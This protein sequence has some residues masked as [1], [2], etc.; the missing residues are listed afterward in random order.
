MV[1][2]TASPVSWR[3]PKKGKKYFTVAEANRA[4][5]YVSRIVDEISEHYQ[6]VMALRKEIEQGRHN[7]TKS[8]GRSEYEL[9]MDRLN[10]LIDELHQ[11]GVELKDLELGLLDFP[12][13]H[14]GREIY[15]CW[16]R[17]EREV[18]AWHEVDAGYAGRQDVSLLA[19]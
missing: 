15:L 16:H 10:E 12:A 18:R 8:P 14:E 5:V 17:G 19:G 3:A 4:L 7:E 11:V 13:V 6:R 2:E 1:P 9:L